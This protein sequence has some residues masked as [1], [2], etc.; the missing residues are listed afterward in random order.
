MR[1][2]RAE[3]MLKSEKDIE[4]MRIAASTTSEIVDELVAAV[5]PG[6]STLDLDR[7]AEE[8]CRR[9]GVTPAFKGLYGFPSCLCVAVNDVVVHGIPSAGVVLREGDIIGLDFGVVYRGWYGDHAR[10]VAVGAV[11]EESSRLVAVTKQ[12]LQ[13]GFEACQPGN[14]L[15]DVGSAVQ[16]CA[17]GAGYSVVRD[18]VGHGIGRRLHEEPSVYNYFDREQL[19]RLRAGMVLC[20]EPMVNIGTADVRLLADE[21][22]AV[23][24]D[25]RRSAHFEH[26]IAITPAGPEVLSISGAGVRAA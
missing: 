13:A 26:T 2:R 9:R 10:T 17:E 6:I 12:A 15:R 21:W 22:T 19:M 11:D 16:R 8:A 14:R 3:I 1:A 18:F 24:A 23:T 4:Q 5:A 25:G 7:L 20:L